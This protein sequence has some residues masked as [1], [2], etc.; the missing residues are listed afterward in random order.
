M[1]MGHG[2]DPLR[3]LLGAPAT[4]PL[5]ANPHPNQAWAAQPK[6]PTVIAKKTDWPLRPEPLSGRL[7]AQITSGKRTHEAESRR[8]MLQC[9]LRTGSRI[10]QGAGEK[11]RRGDRHCFRRHLCQRKAASRL[12]A[13][14]KYSELS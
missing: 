4:F 12:K 14:G 6:A 2:H 7:M 3:R 8:G 11:R 9:S 10:D 5:V 13:R 1:L